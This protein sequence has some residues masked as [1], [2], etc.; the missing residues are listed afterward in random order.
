MGCKNIICI[1]AEITPAIKPANRAM[2]KI[3]K[4]I[5]NPLAINT[6]IAF[7]SIGNQIFNG[8]IYPTK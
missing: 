2:V 7:V 6:K 1:T 8:K 3:L 4:N 5:R